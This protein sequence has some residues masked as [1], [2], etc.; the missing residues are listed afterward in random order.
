[1]IFESDDPQSGRH[2]ART[3]VSSGQEVGH[4]DQD[5]RRPST[6]GA[7][8][9]ALPGLDHVMPVIFGSLTR[10]RATRFVPQKC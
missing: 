8:N 1:V 4:L 5:G 10:R 2:V 9:F 7:T 6:A 3:T